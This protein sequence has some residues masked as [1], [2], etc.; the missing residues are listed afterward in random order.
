MTIT[1]NTNR[2]I[3]PPNRLLNLLHLQPNIFML[4][5]QMSHVRKDFPG[6]ICSGFLDEEAWGFRE[7]E[8]GSEDEED[9]GDDLHGEWDLVLSDRGAWDVFVD[10]V[11]A[12]VAEERGQLVVYLVDADEGAAD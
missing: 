11:I 6:F 1:F 9:G 3:L 2:I 10:D 4:Y 7:D 5:R 12:P 8:E